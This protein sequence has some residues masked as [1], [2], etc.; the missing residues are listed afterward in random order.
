[1]S[2]TLILRQDQQYIE[3]NKHNNISSVLL[4]IIVALIL[5]ITILC[6]EPLIGKPAVYKPFHEVLSFMNNIGHG[7]ASKNFLGN[8]VLFMPLGFL[9]PQI[10]RSKRW[11]GTV[12]SGFC[13]SFIIEGIQFISHRG[14]FDP[15]DIFLNTVGTVFGFG[16][17]KVILVIYKRSI[18]SIVK[19]TEDEYV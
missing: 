19:K 4:G 14:C 3:M 6:R 9:L 12:L 11:F 2:K 18:A 10:Y 7:F 15:D 13:F 17:Y 5:W 1:M 8:I 16:L